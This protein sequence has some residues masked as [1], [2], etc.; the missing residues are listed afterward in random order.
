MAIIKHTSIGYKREP[1]AAPFGFKGGYVNT[2]WHTAVLIKDENNNEGLGLGVQSVLW[3]DSGVFSA[4]SPSGGNSIML[5]MTEYALKLL[6]GETLRH[7]IEILD[8][9]LP[10]V[11]EYGVKITGIPNMKKTFA[12]NA[13]VPV[14]MALWGLYCK[15]SSIAN[16]D[17]IVPEGTKPCLSFRHNKLASIP[18][19]SYG[20]SVDE[21]N[22]LADNGL[23]F[24]K[25]KIGSDP[26]KDNSREK[27]L[28]WDKMR[29]SQV[30]N[31]LGNR[32]TP[33]TADKKIP[34]YLDAN[35]RYDTKDRLMCLLDHAD[36]IGAL[37]RIILLEEPFPEEAEIDVADIPL[38]LVADESAHCVEDCARLIDMGYSGFAIKPIAKTLSMSFLVLECVGKAGLP[39]FCADLTVHPL[40]VDW[41]KNVA[42]RLKPLPGMDIGAIEV[43]GHQNYLNWEKMIHQHP[44]G[45]AGWVGEKN[46]VFE[47]NADFYHHSGGIF[48]DA[49]YYQDLA[50][51]G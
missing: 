37:E 50:V 13:L 30:H 1:L 12:L 15:E 51:M 48:Q 42:A 28:E 8:W 46:G 6:H 7:P 34:Y 5:L 26:D 17:S 10:Q 4:F 35:G 27:M 43:N 24:M 38:R 22:R 3:S 2:V 19:I 20:C 44:M 39:C 11:Y 29:L 31:A 14:D 41:N 45:N 21:I 49:P 47:L 16:F 36:K 9:L 33:Y 40:M 18:L 23:F 25:I 32:A